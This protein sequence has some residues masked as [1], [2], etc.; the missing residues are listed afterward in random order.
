LRSR[1]CATPFPNPGDDM[2]GF[3]KVKDDEEAL[4]GAQEFELDEFSGDEDERGVG[5]GR[6]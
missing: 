6:R 3:T 5:S 2:K 1:D 4:R